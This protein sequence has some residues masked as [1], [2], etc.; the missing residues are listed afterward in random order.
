LPSLEERQL[1]QGIQDQAVRSIKRRGAIVGA[2]I[3]DGLQSG[4]GTKGNADAADIQI[5][6]CLLKCI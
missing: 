3:L 4:A 6:Q 2:N 5:G 1:V